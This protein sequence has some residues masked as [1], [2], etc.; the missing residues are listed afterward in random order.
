MFRNS[1]ILK[2]L[3]VLS[4]LLFCLGWFSF[5]DTAGSRQVL[6]APCCQDCPGFENPGEE[7]TYCSDQC[8]GTG[9]ACYYDCMNWVHS[10]YRWCRLC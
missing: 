1:R 7:V 5:V 2:R 4:A 10:C 8:G 9:N 3:I 6:A